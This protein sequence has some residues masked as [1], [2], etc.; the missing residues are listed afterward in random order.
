MGPHMSDPRHTLHC[1]LCLGAAYSRMGIV[2]PACLNHEQ[3]GRA[4]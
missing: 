4:A 2:V 1:G 3:E